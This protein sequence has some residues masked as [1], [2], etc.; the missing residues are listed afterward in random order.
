MY[1]CVA[2]LHSCNLL[3]LAVTFQPLV[4]IFIII[5]V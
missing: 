1:A 5:Q 2:I 3:M 4:I